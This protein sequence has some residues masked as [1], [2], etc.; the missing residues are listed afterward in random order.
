M[1][2]KKHIQHNTTNK[3]KN[4]GLYLG[5]KDQSNNPTDELQNETESEHVKK[6]QGTSKQ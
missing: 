4:K 2:R 1:T 3:K 5:P 6:L